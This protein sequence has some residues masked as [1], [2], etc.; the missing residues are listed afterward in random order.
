MSLRS[1]PLPD[2]GRPAR[3]SAPGGRKKN[4]YTKNA[5]DTKDAKI[6]VSLALL[7]VLGVTVSLF[8]APFGRQKR[9]GRPRSGRAQ[10][11]AACSTCSIPSAITGA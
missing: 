5:K 1:D 4:R 6:F 8:G 11:P 3:S 7:G 9:A 10:Y 2:R